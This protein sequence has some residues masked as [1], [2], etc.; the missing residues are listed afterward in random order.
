MSWQTQWAA[1]TTQSWLSILEPGGENWSLGESAGAWEIVLHWG[2]GESAA[3]DTGHW[4]LDI[5]SNFPSVDWN[6]TLSMLLFTAIQI[7]HAIP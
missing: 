3:L 4:T 7:H 2:L 6:L 5:L 1:V